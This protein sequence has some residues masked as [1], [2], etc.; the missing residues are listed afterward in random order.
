MSAESRARAHEWAEELLADEFLARLHNF[1]DDGNSR[2]AVN[3]ISITQAQ[4]YFE[5]E[6]A[7]CSVLS[8]HVGRGDVAPLLEMPELSDSMTS[9]PEMAA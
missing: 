6:G 7:P 1:R 9:Q 3:R 5:A 2:F 8:R 4:N